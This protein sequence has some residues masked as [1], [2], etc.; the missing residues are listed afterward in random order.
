MQASHMTP[1]SVSTPAFFVSCETDRDEGMNRKERR[2][3][4]VAR[5]APQKV[6]NSEAARRF[7]E[8]VEHLKS[9]RLDDSD[10][11]HRR[12]LSLVP[13]HAPTLHHLGLIAYKRQ[14]LEAAVGFIRRSLSFAPEDRKSV[15]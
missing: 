10:A 13:N 14:D 8:A 4:A 9:G 5:P 2:S 6:Q 7:R 12:V 1:E 15:V 11:A 3:T